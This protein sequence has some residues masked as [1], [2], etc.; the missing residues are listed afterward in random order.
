MPSLAKFSTP[1]HDVFGPTSALYAHSGVAPQAAGPMNY[2]YEVPASYSTSIQGFGNSIFASGSPQRK[3][4]PPLSTAQNQPLFTSPYRMA[5]SLSLG[6]SQANNAPGSSMPQAPFTPRQ[7]RHDRLSISGN[8][9]GPV[10]TTS[11]DGGPPNNGTPPKTAQDLLL[12]VLGTT[13]GGVAPESAN[14]GGMSNVTGRPRL[15]ASPPRVNSSGS[16]PDG[17]RPA[18]LLF[19]A[20]T[21]NS[22]WAP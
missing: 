10:M 2:H 20:S 5:G 8:P 9:P 3:N 19:G 4:Q 12:R 15:S 17:N 11:R 6:N 7:Q 14:N 1:Q 16:S 18:P 21:G 22:I 13:P